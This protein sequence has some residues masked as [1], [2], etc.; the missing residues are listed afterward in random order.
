MFN[1]RDVNG[2]WVQI[3]VTPVECH[4]FIQCWRVLYNRSLIGN[5]TPTGPYSGRMVLG[6]RASSSPLGLKLFREFRD[7]GVVRIRIPLPLD[8]PADRTTFA[9]DF[10]QDSVDF[11][12]QYPLSRCLQRRRRC[13]AIVLEI[14]Q[15]GQRTS[16]STFLLGDLLRNTLVFLHEVLCKQFAFQ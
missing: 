1:E 16:N 9:Y 2:N 3:R 14:L 10:P 12:Q 15:I 11:I 5:S 7:T 6:P 4:T 13:V 8:E